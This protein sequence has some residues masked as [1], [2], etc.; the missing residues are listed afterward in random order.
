[1]CARLGKGGHRFVK[2]GES[3][4]SMAEVH[5]HGSKAQQRALEAPLFE[6][7]SRPFCTEFKQY[8]VFQKTENPYAIQ[9]C[10]AICIQ[11]S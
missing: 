9:C 1:M 8:V 2:G 6:A 4:R 7:F 11:T 10:A 5:V 3:L